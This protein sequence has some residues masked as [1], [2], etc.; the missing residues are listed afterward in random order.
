MNTSSEQEILQ[1]PPKYLQ[2][3]RQC[4]EIQAFQ[5]KRY[6]NSGRP[7]ITANL[8]F[9]VCLILLCIFETVHMTML[10]LAI[11]DNVLYS[12]PL[13]LFLGLAIAFHIR[14]KIFYIPEGEFDAIVDKLKP[15]RASVRPYQKPSSKSLRRRIR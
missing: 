12:F 14:R 2:K 3:H 6:S 10:D 15:Q 8:A 5:K 13:A 7:R 1:Y 9:I 11:L 4:N